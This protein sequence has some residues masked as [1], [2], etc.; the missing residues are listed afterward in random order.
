MTKSLS[1]LKRRIFDARLGNPLWLPN[2]CGCP[3]CAGDEWKGEDFA[4]QCP[5]RVPTPSAFDAR[6]LYAKIAPTYP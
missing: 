2:L 6:A 5:T 4:F 1:R 3:I